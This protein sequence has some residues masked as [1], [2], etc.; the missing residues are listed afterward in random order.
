ML[1]HNPPRRRGEKPRSRVSLEPC[2]RD[3]AVVQS[4]FFLPSQPV[5][6]SLADGQMEP[7]RQHCGPAH[8]GRQEPAPRTDFQSR[9]HDRNTSMLSSLIF[10]GTRY[11]SGK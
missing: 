1:E 5:Q 11:R 9:Q 8:L 3:Q 7:S 2:R 4:N 6:L 10:V